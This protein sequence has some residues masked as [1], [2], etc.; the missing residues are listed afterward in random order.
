[1]AKEKQTLRIR[2]DRKR[3]FQFALSVIIF[4]LVI[5]GGG[6]TIVVFI[7]CTCR[8]PGQSFFIKF[9]NKLSRLLIHNTRRNE[10]RSIDTFPFHTRRR[11][12]IRMCMR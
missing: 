4:I 1:M 6:G 11:G 10:F 9:D 5:V 2:T 8:I 12:R 3:K 7:S